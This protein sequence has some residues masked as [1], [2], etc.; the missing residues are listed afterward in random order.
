[1]PK[2]RSNAGN[3][4]PFPTL[5]ADEK[6]IKK[7]VPIFNIMHDTALSE[8]EAHSLLDLLWRYANEQ[9]KGT[10]RAK[11]EPT[12]IVADA[13]K[14]VIQE[15]RRYYNQRPFILDFDGIDIEITADMSEVEAMRKGMDATLSQTLIEKS[16]DD[17]LPEITPEPEP[18]PEPVKHR[19]KVI[20]TKPDVV[21]EKPEPR[22]TLKRK[23]TVKAEPAPEPAIPEEDEDQSQYIGLQTYGVNPGEPL[24][25][26][27]ARVWPNRPA[28]LIY[29]DKTIPIT[30]EMSLVDA[31]IEAADVAGVDG[32]Q[33]EEEQPK[34]SSSGFL[35]EQA[36]HPYDVAK[37]DYP[38]PVDD[39]EWQV[40]YDRNSGADYIYTQRS[41]W[42]DD[43]PYRISCIPFDEYMNTQTMFYVHCKE[44]P[45]Q[46]MFDCY[47]ELFRKHTH[48]VHVRQSNF[49]SDG[50]KILTHEYCSW[51]PKENSVEQ[52]GN[53]ISTVMEA[54]G[55]NAR[56]EPG[57]RYRIRYWD[58]NI[59]CVN[60]RYY[61]QKPPEGALTVLKHPK[62]KPVIQTRP[63]GI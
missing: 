14:T 31:Q 59:N 3:D 32:N 42:L 48:K 18:A 15:I 19:K 21:E 24:S 17:S 5:F 29:Q 4:I 27:V 20:K 49:G 45:S 1:M 11:N 51:R 44:R 38:I 36:P 41:V 30:V 26:A 50:S 7:V 60:H 58:T 46:A 56:W 61:Q 63:A 34:I 52:S 2:A 53:V 54:L 22:P 8:K 55:M 28:L 43:Y 16:I 25:R 40:S 47:H 39:S 12:I 33:V 6:L 23:P 62:L 37:F 10:E 9:A 35:H 13:G 57:A